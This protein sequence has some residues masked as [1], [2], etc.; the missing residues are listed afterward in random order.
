M[1]V[2]DHLGGDRRMPDGDVTPLG[3][4]DMKRVVVHVRLLGFGVMVGA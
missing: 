2:Q 3:I 4:E 1:P